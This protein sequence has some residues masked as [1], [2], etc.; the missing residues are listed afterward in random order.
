MLDNLC[1]TIPCFR[2]E[3][4]KKTFY[5]TIFPLKFYLVSAQT[6]FQTKKIWLSYLNLV[7]CAYCLYWFGLMYRKHHY[8]MI[9]FIRIA[10]WHF[11]QGDVIR[12]YDFHEQPCSQRL[13]SWIT[14]TH[15]MTPILWQEIQSCFVWLWNV[16]NLSPQ[17]YQITKWVW[18]LIDIYVTS[19]W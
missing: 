9:R 4:Q 14:K 11:S 10:F 17:L 13:G 2:T 8:N 18:T 6:I 7:V 12:V 15:D 1:P 16:Y 5:K 19:V 3:K